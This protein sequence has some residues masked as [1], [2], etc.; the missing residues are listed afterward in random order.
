MPH[1][2]KPYPKYEDSGVEW[3]GDVPEGWETIKLKHCLTLVTKKA[4]NKT[5]PIALENIESWTGRY[6]KTGSDFEGD[7]VTFKE[8][9]ILFG[10]LRPYLAKVLH[11]NRAGEAVG[12]IFVYRPQAT[13]D[14][15]YYAKVLRTKEAINIIDSSTYGAKMPR[16]SSE[17]IGEFRI[18]T[19]PI[20]EQRAIAAFLDHETGKVDELIEKQQKLIELLDEKR[21]AVISHAVTKGLNPNAPMKD[22]GI[23]WLGDVPKHWKVAPLKRLAGMIG[24]YAFNSNDFTESGV[25]LLKIANVYKNRLSLERQPT[26]LP[27]DFVKKHTSFVI[28]RND[29]IM[30]LTGTL[31]KRDYGFAVLINNDGPF[32]LNQR[33]AKLQPD[34]RYILPSYLVKLLHSNSYLDQLYSLPSGTKQANLSNNDVLNIK[35]TFPRSLEEQTQVAKYVDNNLVKFDKLISKAKSAI[36]LMRER[37]TA[38]ISAAVTGKI[39]VRE[40]V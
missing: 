24:G 20:H 10:K 9:D 30:S 8:D 19:P 22:S 37:R 16:A 4:S 14:G 12:D 36:D 31:G 1:K 5:F 27:N 7:G 32:L 2:Y 13:S 34:K 17:F 33:V 15:S 25:Q 21:Q 35:V 28:N 40:N 11:A 18:P 23:E 29:I 6:I 26:F 38:L 3:V 39:D